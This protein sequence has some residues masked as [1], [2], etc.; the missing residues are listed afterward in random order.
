[1]DQ[2]QA[3]LASVDELKVTIEDLQTR[4]TPTTTLPASA[5]TVKP[6]SADMHDP[7]YTIDEFENQFKIMAQALG[8]PEERQVA[9]LPLFLTGHAKE[10][11]LS[12]PAA[13][14]VNLETLFHAL[15]LATTT[16]D[17]NR[18]AALQL[19][20]RKQA[21]SET[22]SS[23]AADVK[24]LA[25]VAFKSS[26][27]DTSDIMA[28]QAFLNG[29][30]P[31]LKKVVL[32]QSPDSIDEAILLASKE[33]ITRKVLD[34]EKLKESSQ[35]NA[36]TQKVDKLIAAVNTPTLPYRNQSLSYNPVPTI[37]GNH[38]GPP[39]CFA[40]GKFGH[41]ARVCRTPMR[42]NYQTQN[43][44]LPQRQRQNQTNMGP[45]ST[46]YQNR[47]PANATWQPRNQ[48]RNAQFR[49]PNQSNSR[50]Q[51][52]RQTRP[53]VNMIDHSQEPDDQTLYED[54]ELINR[55]RSETRHSI[56]FCD[57]IG[58]QQASPTALT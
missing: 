23:F 22:V 24:R 8:W 10:V 7:N 44:S 35:V 36:L 20:S 48:N 5:L 2:L 47:R 14:K 30:L 18:Y 52:N 17:M 43:Y 56:A 58:Q 50:F 40:C 13:D 4:V 27:G 39:K 57:K 3:L 31:S 42:P 46:R 34:E 11:Y 15:K 28:L 51:Q 54:Q 55:F 6:F 38:A 49:F 37:S 25:R 29:L 33:Q 53:F 1:M 19:R 9:I 16:E 12:L 41:I 26:G 32:R 21:P 45:P